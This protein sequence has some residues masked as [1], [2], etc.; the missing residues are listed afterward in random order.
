MSKRSSYTF[1]AT[2]DLA[3]VFSVPGLHNFDVKGTYGGPKRS[4]PLQNW[5]PLT[6]PET[7]NHSSQRDTTRSGCSTSAEGRQD[8]TN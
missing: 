7:S 6:T 3:R 2:A 4:P 5:A 8:R 1:D